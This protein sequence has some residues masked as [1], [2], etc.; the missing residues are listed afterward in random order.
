ME[1]KKVCFI[2]IICFV[3]TVV[4]LINVATDKNELGL[5]AEEIGVLCV[6]NLYPN[7][8]RGLE[9]RDTLSDNR[10]VIKEMNQ[11]KEKSVVDLEEIVDINNELISQ[12]DN[13]MANY[14]EMISDKDN[15]NQQGDNDKEVTEIVTSNNK[16]III[17]HT[18]ATE[19]YQPKNEG[20]F[21]NVEEEG[22]VREVGNVLKSE[23][24]ALGYSVIHDKTLHDAESYNKSY[25]R[26]METLKGILNDN[27]NKEIAA[28]IDLHRDAASYMGNVGKT[29]LID[30]ETSANYALVVGK[31]N[32]N[33]EKLNSL[34]I[35]LN[36]TAEKMYPGF[37]G[38]II[39]KPYK[40]NQSI[41]DRCILLEIGNN[42]NNIRDARLCGKYFARVL[43]ETLENI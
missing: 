36:E 28:I 5:S 6:S 23:L 34:A 24:E 14:E 29:V 18:H 42:E 37:G 13:S 19:S 3:L 31:G 27:K 12:N 43:A 38:R 7:I 41:S 9:K 10:L 15:L 35:A 17:Y 22:T 30:G 26:S 1:I 40:Y 8:T 11:D 25:S 32:S 4:Y 33:Y 16:M 39:T 20:N 21:H 2:S